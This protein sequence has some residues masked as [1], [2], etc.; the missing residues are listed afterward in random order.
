MRLPNA[1]PSLTVEAA[2]SGRLP[3]FIA[4]AQPQFDNLRLVGEKPATLTVAAGLSDDG[5]EVIA[6]LDQPT[7]PSRGDRVTAAA[8]FAKP[9]KLGYGSAAQLMLPLLTACVAM[10]TA[11]IAEAV[12]R[13]A[14]ERPRVVVAGSTGRL[15]AVLVQLLDK[16]GA[17]AIVAGR[18]QDADVMRRMG[19][20][21]ALD[22]NE[23]DFSSQCGGTLHA[24]LDTLGWEDSPELIEEYLDAKYV[25]LASPPLR[26][27]VEEGAV[28]ALRRRWQPEPPGVAWLPDEPLLESIGEVLQCL[29]EGTFTAPKEE[30]GGQTQEL[31]S[32][33]AEYIGWKRDGDTGKRLGFPGRDLWAPAAPSRGEYVSAAN[34]ASDVSYSSE[35]RP[36]NIYVPEI[37]VPDLPLPPFE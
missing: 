32:Q 8:A 36:P 10:E 12:A 29:D 1:I 13:S 2:W 27:L 23:Q 33:Y 18:P 21:T 25:S 26:S 16:R 5:D 11:C 4:P 7:T 20:A 31:A 15:P 37:D 35:R 17:E 14:A 30:F 28:A 24:V 19:A 3:Q 22:H 9:R 34:R 6:L